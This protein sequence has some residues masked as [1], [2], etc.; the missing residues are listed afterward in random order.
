VADRQT[1]GQSDGIVRSVQSRFAETQFAETPTLTLT[2]NPNF[3][4]TGFGETGRHCAL[5]M[6]A[7]AR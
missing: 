2:L 4:E 7:V 6:F 3:G 5:C 1:D